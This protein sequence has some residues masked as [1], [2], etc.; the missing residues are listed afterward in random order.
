MQNCRSLIGQMSSAE[1]SHVITWWLGWYD[2][3]E[4]VILAKLLLG[5]EAQEKTQM[6]I[7][8]KKISLFLSRIRPVN[9]L[10]LKL[11]LAKWVKIT[12][13]SYLCRVVCLHEMKCSNIFLANAKRNLGVKNAS[14]QDFLLQNRPQTRN[15]LLHT[16]VFSLKLPHL[17]KSSPRIGHS[18]WFSALD[19][20]KVIQYLRQHKLQNNFVFCCRRGTT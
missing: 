20:Q 12:F 3:D 15:V 16:D 11:T 10:A 17:K 1:I 7:D 14:H 4:K 18:P 6:R 8:W 5:S 9:L 19:V 13:Q 2:P